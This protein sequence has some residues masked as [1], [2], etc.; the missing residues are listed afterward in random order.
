MRQLWA[1]S[2]HELVV[3]R[4]GQHAGPQSHPRMVSNLLSAAQH[5]EYG[6]HMAQA[7]LD[8]A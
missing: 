8:H 4:C 6:V 3:M 7:Q 5:D 1:A 2:R